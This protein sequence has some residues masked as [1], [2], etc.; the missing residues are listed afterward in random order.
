MVRTPSPIDK[1]PERGV[2][3]AVTDNTRSTETV[4]LLSPGSVH[5][6][7]IGLDTETFPISRDEPIPRLVCAQFCDGN[8]TAVVHVRDPALP[9]ALGA[10]FDHGVV[11]CNAPFDVF[12]IWR[13]FPHLLPQIVEAYKAG[14]AHDVEIRERLIDIA[15]GGT[16]RNG[17]Y[18]LAALAHRRAG[19]DLDKGEDTYRLRYG[20]LEP[21]PVEAW[22]ADAVTYAKR[23]AAATWAVWWYQEQHGQAAA[24]FADEAAQVRAHLALDAQSLR[25]ILTDQVQVRALRGRLD[26]EIDAFTAI[27]LGAGLV[28]HKHKVLR[29]SPL[30]SSNKLAQQMLEDLASHDPSIRIVR[31]DPTSKHPAGQVSLSEDALAAARIPGGHPLDAFRRRKTTITQRTGWVVP[32]SSPVVRTGY[33]PLVDSGRTSSGPPG[34]P[35]TED[36]GRNL[37]NFPQRGGF[38]EC[39]VAP[40][41]S[42]FVVSDFGSLE[43][44]T[45][46][47]DQ[48]DLFGRSALAEALRA[49]RNPHD[50]VTARI[51]GLAFV[52]GD[53]QAIAKA[54]AAFEKT[55]T[56]AKACNFGFPGGLGPRRFVEYALQDPYNVV[57]TEAEARS[58]KALWLEQW[59]EDRLTFEYVERFSDHNGLYTCHQPRTGRIRGGCKYTDA[60]NSRFQGLGADV[61]KRAAWGLFLATI[62]FGRGGRANPLFGAYVVLFV[63]DEF[64]TEVAAERAEAARAEQDR[65]MIEAAAELCPD[66]PIKVG[67]RVLERYKK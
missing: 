27:C 38:R 61:A 33:D 19:L 65:I 28:R 63:H 23:D 14:R 21:Y 17:T 54:H 49:G 5:L 48:L 60:C 32:L 31:T 24:I 45:R 9:A 58:L 64:V 56:L 16:F 25:G 20:T 1:P 43:L 3:R 22:P 36:E 57:V 15:G 8:T 41:G 4:F 6:S 62:G 12:V 37:Q 2:Q 50:E 59:P 42:V 30:V 34:L 35:W 66:V 13:Q 11:L 26:A 52:T 39:L 18:S 10:A 51:L 44:V 40:P 46:A 29:P 47:Q 55:R 7:M 53:D 67:S